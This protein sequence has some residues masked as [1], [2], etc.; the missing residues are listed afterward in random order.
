MVLFS[1]Q[2]KF[3]AWDPEEERRRQEKWQQEQERLLQ[4]GRP[5]AG[6]VFLLDAPFISIVLNRFLVQD[7]YGITFFSEADESKSVHLGPLQQ[8]ALH[9]IPP[10]KG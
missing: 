9:L 10:T 6:L 1:K 4:V 7:M 5:C 2:F 8:N 3:W